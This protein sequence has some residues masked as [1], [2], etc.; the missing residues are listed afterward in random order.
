MA[1]GVQGE[2]GGGVVL[3]SLHAL[4]A[5]ALL[6][7]VCLDVYFGHD[8]RGCA[9]TVGKSVE[10]NL[11]RGHA[12]SLWKMVKK[13]FSVGATFLLSVSLNHF[14]L[15]FSSLQMIPDA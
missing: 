15:F 3:F 13:Y 6:T 14:C 2:K 9:G 11:T 7:R 8:M 12:G 1:D 10:Q 4:L 5:T